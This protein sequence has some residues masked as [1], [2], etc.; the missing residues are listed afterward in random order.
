MDYWLCGNYWF[1]LC[2]FCCLTVVSARLM[3]QREGKIGLMGLGKVSLGRK[4]IFDQLD[5][6]HELYQVYLLSCRARFK[7]DHF[8]KA[9]F[10]DSTAIASCSI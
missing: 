7:V 2:D 9:T 10:D 1:K 5:H 4:L 3:I 6:H 8:C